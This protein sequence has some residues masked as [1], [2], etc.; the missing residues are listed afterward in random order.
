M[1]PEIAK[2]IYN[3]IDSVGQEALS[4]YIDE[5][6]HSLHLFLEAAKDEHILKYQGAIEE[7]RKILRLRDTAEAVLKMKVKNG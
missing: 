4:A 5:R 2:K 6:I 7:L 1:T 3:N